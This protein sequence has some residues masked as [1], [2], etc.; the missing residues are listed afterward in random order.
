MAKKKSYDKSLKK[1]VDL[2][3]GLLSLA[4]DKAEKRIKN[5]RKRGDLNKK[6][7]EKMV[8]DIS[9]RV[10]KEQD[11]VLKT[12]HKELKKAL[13]TAG[14]EITI[15]TKKSKKTKKKKTSKKKTRKKKKR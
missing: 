1:A 3:L 10:R 11:R 5:L 2:S 7:A 4:G 8:K 6:D 12:V 15:K 14:I 9:K 13:N